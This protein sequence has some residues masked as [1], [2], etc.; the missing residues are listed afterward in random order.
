MNIYFFVTKSLSKKKVIIHCQDM[1]QILG[2]IRL[3]AY[4]KNKNI[5][6]STIN[7]KN[8]LHS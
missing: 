1:P 5:F 7:N 2:V 4:F 3:E 8:A 6:F